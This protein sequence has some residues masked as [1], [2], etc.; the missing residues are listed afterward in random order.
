MTKRAVVY[1]RISRDKMGAGLGVAEQELQCRELAERFGYE[2]VFVYVDNDLSA[3]SGRPRPAYLQMLAALR[4][5]KADAVLCWH[6]DRLHRSNT[7]LEDYIQAVEPHNVQT[8]TVK[9]G[10]IDL[11]TPSGRMIA[12][13]L[14][15]IAR[16][17]SEHRAERVSAAR[18]RQARQGIYGGGRRPY[19]FEAD[20]VTIRPQEAQEIARWSYALLSGVPLRSITRDLI[21]R[22]VPT[23]SGNRWQPPAV[24]DILLRPRN[25][26]FM[27]HRPIGGDKHRGNGRGYTD[28]HIVGKAPWEPIIPEDVWRAVV[29]KLTDPERKTTPGPAPRWLGSGLYRCHCGEGMRC[30]GKSR[31]DKKV[32]Y[33]RCIGPGS[34]HSAMR[35]DELDPLVNK[36]AVM[37]LSREDL[38]TLIPQPPEGPSVAE[39]HAELAVHRQRLEHLDDD[40]D[41]DRI[42]RAQYLRGTEKRRTK[43]SALESQLDAHQELSP[44]A[45]FVGAADPGALWDKLSLGEKRTVLRELMTITVKPVGRGRRIS[46]PLDRVDFTDPR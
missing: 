39:L 22:D 26:G 40:Y 7:E 9:A 23:A 11:S 36:A 27:V 10:P 46:D 45:Q 2:V 28:D 24:R 33:Y 3:Y 21:E 15:T 37:R 34:G 19:G 12:R 17:E 32:F 6:T 14:C 44:L 1:V 42:T 20:G 29:A 38:A 41:N 31:Q 5:G 25:A 16:Y 35:A 13:Q 30:I 8:Q 4:E 43:I 18:A